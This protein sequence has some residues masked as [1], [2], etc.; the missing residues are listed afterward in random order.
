[1]LNSAPYRKNNSKVTYQ[2]ICNWFSNQRA[3]NRTTS[4]SGVSQTTSIPVATV[5]VDV[6]AKFNGS[7]GYNPQADGQS[8]TDVSFYLW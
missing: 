8:E 6:K 3:Q 2:Q 1:M 5:P 7:N 4:V